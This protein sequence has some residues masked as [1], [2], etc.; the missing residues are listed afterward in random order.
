MGTNLRDVSLFFFVI[1]FTECEAMTHGGS[2]LPATERGSEP[3][4]AVVGRVGV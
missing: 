2:T 4:P 1:S 3:A